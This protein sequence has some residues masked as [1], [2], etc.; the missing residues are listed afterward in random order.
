MNIIE[1]KKEKKKK[2]NATAQMKSS[3]TVCIRFFLCICFLPETDNIYVRFS[4]VRKQKKEMVLEA[5]LL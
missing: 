5:Y 2:K 4:K 1:K 3:L